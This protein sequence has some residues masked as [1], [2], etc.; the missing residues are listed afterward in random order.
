M[1]TSVIDAFN[2][3][4]RDQVNL[5]PADTN[6]ARRSRDWLVDRI[7]EFPGKE[8]SFPILCNYKDIFF[9]SFE[10]RTKK[11]PL[12]D[13]DI[14]VGLD[15][16]G[17]VYYEYGSK[18][19]LSTF[20]ESSPLY[21][22]RFDNSEYINSK[23]VINKFVAVLAGL[24]HYG[25]AEIGRRGEAAILN[26]K[27]YAWAYDIVPCFF[28]NPDNQGNWFYII[29]DGEGH[30][31]RTDPRIDRARVARLVAA[32]GKHILDVIRLV[33][34]WNR[35][36]TMPS[37]PSYLLEN[38]VLDYYELST[39][40]QYPDLEFRDVIDYLRTAIHTPVY[41]PKGVQGDLNT[42][43]WIDRI[44]IAVRCASDH[45]KCVEARSFESE[46]DYRHSINKWG[47]VFGPA[48]PK[49]G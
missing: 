39:C 48:F 2:E 7:H 14:M 20:N 42:I 10:R 22:L 41:D 38:M 18:I 24:P 34:F 44:A 45:E 21:N 13:I 16:Q 30:W 19:Y 43:D 25:K 9:G 36:P 47:E 31:Q 46:Y 32:R 33:K 1:A 4:L 35:R 26:L 15:A 17:T 11:R 12:D 49:F 6:L 29:P 27:S 40:S 3:F 28:T 37:L 8:S 5:D 23:R